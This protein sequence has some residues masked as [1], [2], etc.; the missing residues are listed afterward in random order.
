MVMSTKSAEADK[1]CQKLDLTDQPSSS[2]VT[3]NVQPR[4]RYRQEGDRVVYRD[5]ILL[6]NLKYNTFVNI[7]TDLLLEARPDE[8]VQ[9]EFRPKSPKRRR[10]PQNLFDSFEANI[11]QNFQKLMIICYRN[12]DDPYQSDFELHG[13]DVVRLKHAESGGFITVDDD[14]KEPNGLQEAYVR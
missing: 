13:G 8:S 1:T 2:R 12:N 11:S 9:C 4:Y 10:D 3:F 5:Q 7:S 6:A 14:S